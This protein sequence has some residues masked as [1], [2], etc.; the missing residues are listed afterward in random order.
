MFYPNIY[1]ELGSEDKENEW[2]AIVKQKMQREIKVI[3]PTKDI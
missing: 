1:K 3:D 2:I